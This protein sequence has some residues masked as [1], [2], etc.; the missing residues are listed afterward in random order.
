VIAFDGDRALRVT[1]H[2]TSEAA[3][4]SAAGTGA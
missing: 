4:S 2:A 3:L 1:G